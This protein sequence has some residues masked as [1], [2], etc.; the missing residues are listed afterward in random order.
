M[1]LSLVLLE[2]SSHDLPMGWLH[3]G[4]VWTIFLL[5][6]IQS[7][8]SIFTL[9]RTKR[10]IFIVSDSS[11]MLGKFQSTITTDYT[12][13]QSI[14]LIE[15]SLQLP[16]TDSTRFNLHW[17]I[18][19][20]EVLL[21]SCMHLPIHLAIQYANLYTLYAVNPCHFYQITYT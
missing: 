15:N 1:H 17:L 5:K 3:Q 2:T 4:S 7:E 6:K 14:T 20:V 19:S 11:I 8:M 18:F 16:T 9:N 21:S 12:A 10:D 13:V